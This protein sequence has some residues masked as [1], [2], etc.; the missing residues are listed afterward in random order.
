VLYKGGK[1]N[2]DETLKLNKDK[3][4]NLIAKY[5]KDK[6]TEEKKKDMIEF[7]NN[8]RKKSDEDETKI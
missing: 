4:I 8:I 5:D 3:Q 6:D 7:I 2:M 1:K